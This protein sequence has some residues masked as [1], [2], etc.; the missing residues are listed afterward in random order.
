MSKAGLEMLTKASAVDL[1][2]L[3][4]RVNA[5]APGVTDKNMFRYSG[6]SESEYLFFK[7]RAG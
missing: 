5:V 2:P 6:L 4:V 1:A 7:K 3:G